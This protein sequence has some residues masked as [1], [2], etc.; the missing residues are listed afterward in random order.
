M[1][2]RGKDYAKAEKKV[3]R[4]LEKKVEK[5]KDVH[6]AFLLVRRLG[7]FIRHF[8]K[9]QVRELLDIITVAHAV[10]TKDVAV[11]PEL[12]NDTCGVHSVFSSIP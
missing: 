12:L 3:R 8:Q 9:Q 5:D 2:E 7:A 4:L 10:V 6:N 1:S 11:V